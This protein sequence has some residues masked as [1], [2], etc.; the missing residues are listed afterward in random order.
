MAD[1]RCTMTSKRK[2]GEEPSSEIRPVVES[3][4]PTLGQESEASF[5]ESVAAA[6]VLLACRVA[7]AKRGG[8]GIEGQHHLALHSPSTDRPLTLPW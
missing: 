6:A 3:T 2:R 5:D 8:G 4:P 1:E 7:M